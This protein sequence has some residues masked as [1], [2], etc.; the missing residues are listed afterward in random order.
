MM[1]ASTPKSILTSAALA[2]ALLSGTALTTPAHAAS[3]L[4]QLNTIALMKRELSRVR[5]TEE[6]VDRALYYLDR[7]PEMQPELLGVVEELRPDVMPLVTQ[8]LGTSVHAEVGAARVATKEASTPSKLF[9]TT[10]KKAAWAG[11]GAVVIGGGI[12]ALSGGGGGKSS[13]G[14]GTPDTPSDPDPD[15]PVTED[16]DTFDT[17]EYRRNTGNHALNANQAYARGVT[18][19]GVIV[20][21]L[22]D[23]VTQTNTVDEFPTISLSRDYVGQDNSPPELHANFIASIVAGTRNDS[24]SHGIAY[25][26]TLYDYK[27]STESGV[28]ADDATIGQAY[29]DAHNDGVL[30]LN[31]S[32]GTNN[33]L[34]APQEGDRALIDAAFGNEIAAI[35][36][37][38]SNGGSD[39]GTVIV[40]STGNESR[41]QPSFE[42]LFPWYYPELEGNVLTVTALNANFNPDNYDPATVQLA[43]YANRC[44][45]AMNWCLTAPGTDILTENFNGTSFRISGTSFATPFVVGAAAL[46]GQAF[47]NLTVEEIVEI[48][49]V[50]AT[51][52]GA[53]GVDPVFGYGLVNLEQAFEPVGQT[54]TLS[55]SGVRYTP[56]EGDGSLSGTRSFSGLGSSTVAVPVYDSYDRRFDRS[57]SSF[58]DKDAA[59]LGLTNRLGRMLDGN[60]V[61]A[62]FETPDG[63]R[64]LVSTAG[65]VTGTE[66]SYAF[67]GERTELFGASDIRSQLSFGLTARDEGGFGL[68]YQ[69]SDD[70]QGFTEFGTGANYLY[71][72]PGFSVPAGKGAFDTALV[73]MREQGTILGEAGQDLFETDGVS[74]SAGL[75]S[76]YRLALSDKFSLSANAALVQVSYEGG[77]NFIAALDGTAARAELAAAYRSAGLEGVLSLESPLHY[78]AGHATTQH[79]APRVGIVTDKSALSQE[80]PLLVNIKASM[81]FI[82]K[83][84]R[85]RAQLSYA[86]NDA[87]DPNRGRAEMIVGLTV[88]F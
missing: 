35:R 4:R 80:A 54:S 32:Y 43:G 52:L 88:Q 72:A 64:H 16:P 28:F 17:A 24:Q 23:G 11:G 8:R 69:L 49:L 77:N 37:F 45:A 67:R 41:S 50:T 2:L 87:T 62:K 5:G 26:A 85:A 60:S 65:S 48:L 74:V 39:R 59:T 30:V 47:P 78:I 58:A 36:T 53:E 34:G 22:D 21:I 10:W 75:V 3:E 7:Y 6:F 79:F 55:V 1:S 83:S 71:A 70:V 19:Q 82:R 12:L 76:Q 61:Q 33:S 38:K 51:D 46:L 20:G 13:S 25:G 56:E 27:I 9:D 29:T 15:L 14:T 86:L 42:S 18:G 40:Y 63:A 84:A 66:K 73:V 81:P 57:A 68:R 44:G 31:A